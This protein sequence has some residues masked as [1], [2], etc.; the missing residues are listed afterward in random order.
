MDGFTRIREPSYLKTLE[1]SVAQ[2][3]NAP[4]EKISVPTLVIAGDE[5]Q[6]YPPALAQDLARRIPGAR[7]EMMRGLGH[8]PNMEQ[9]EEF[10]A[11]LLRFLKEQEKR[12]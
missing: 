9:P 12:S 2:D 1:A 6:V 7:L 5:D 8:L 4:I 11:V 10:N 3:R